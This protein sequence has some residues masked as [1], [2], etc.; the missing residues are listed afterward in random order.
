M[1]W[2]HHRRS[3]GDRA[4][5]GLLFIAIGVI[6]LLSNLGWY[7]IGPLAKVW[8]PAILIIFGIKSLFTFRGSAALISFAFWA[9]SGLLFLSSTLGYLPIR[10]GQM[11]W[12]VLIIWSGVLVATGA[13]PR[14][15]SRC[16]DDGSEM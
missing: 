11:I 6:L 12:P 9:G 13:I 3:T 14:C 4:F 2:R 8:W 5:S 7:S 1:T 10:V 16:V 15:G